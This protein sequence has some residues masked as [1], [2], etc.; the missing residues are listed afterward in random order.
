M[1]VVLDASVTVAWFLQDES[2]TESGPLL[3]YVAK[4][5]AAVP[6]IWKMEVANVFT[7]AV[8][9][10]RIS[11]SHRERAMAALRAL[12]I[13]EDAEGTSNVWTTVVDIA[14]RFQLSIYD[15][16]YLELSA[17]TGLPIATADKA[18]KAAALSMGRRLYSPDWQIP[19]N[20]TV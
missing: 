14:D 2:S 15:A 17:R 12:P 10:G 8:R 3:N 16:T 5:G 7:Q 11:D 1:R 9:R 19:D 20:T 18:M 4:A 6:Q 13:R